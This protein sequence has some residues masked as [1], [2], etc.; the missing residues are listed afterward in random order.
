MDA[1]GYMNACSLLYYHHL[2]G[3]ESGKP[4][5][6]SWS[7]ILTTGT[8]ADIFVNVKLYVIGLY[9]NIEN[10][11]VWIT[12]L[13]DTLPIGG[14]KFK[15]HQIMDLKSLYKKFGLNTTLLS[16]DL[17]SS[18]LSLGLTYIAFNGN[19]LSPGSG[20]WVTPSVCISFKPWFLL[21]HC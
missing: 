10:H 8:F 5:E 19:P 14:F 9:V 17:P 20:H 1:F 13:L 15:T 18:F 6:L 7:E 21:V 3:L 11:L 2:D 4:S 12:C 16:I